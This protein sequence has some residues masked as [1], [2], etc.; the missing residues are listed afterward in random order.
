M[1]LLTDTYL[2][3]QMGPQ[4]LHPPNNIY[5]F[6]SSELPSKTQARQHLGYSPMK[7]RTEKPIKST[8]MID[9]KRLWDKNFCCFKFLNLWYFVRK[10]KVFLNSAI[11]IFVMKFIYNY[12]IIWEGHYYVLFSMSKMY[13]REMK[14]FL[15]DSV[16]YT[17]ER[18]IPLR[19]FRF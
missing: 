1:W 16:Q 4:E 2:A 3:S 6:E 18:Q 7:P 8:C 10:A 9:I 5:E 15:E 12:P 13:L 17:G 11:F 19:S 14:L